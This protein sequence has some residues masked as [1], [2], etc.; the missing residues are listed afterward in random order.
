MEDTDI[1]WNQF[2][3]NNGILKNPEIKPL[4]N[5]FLNLVQFTYQLKLK[6]DSLIHQLI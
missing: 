1:A 4:K 6:L 5:F 2:I 3:R